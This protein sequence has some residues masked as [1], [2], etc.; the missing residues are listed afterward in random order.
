M[1]YFILKLIPFLLLL[2]VFSI[3]CDDKSTD[4]NNNTNNINNTQSLP[5]REDC[6]HFFVYEGQGASSVKLVGSFNEW[7]I[8][9]GYPF[10][11]DGFNWTLA[12]TSN[13]NHED[14]GIIL[15]PP[16]NYPYKFVI[17]DETWIM[18]NKNPYTI[19]DKTQ[20]FEN[21]LLSLP[22]CNA[23]QIYEET[24]EIDFANG[25]LTFTFQLALS[26]RNS[27]ISD[28]QVTVYE[29]EE[30]IESSLDYDNDTGLGSVSLQGLSLGKFNINIIAT[31]T[32]GDK[33]DK[34]FA[35]WFEE[36]NKNWEDLILYSIFV[37]RF[38]NGDPT[39]DKPVEDLEEIVNWQG[40][41]WKG[42]TAKIK[43]GYFDDLGIN[44][45]WIS[46][47]MDN[48]DYALPGDCNQVF[49]GYHAY[50]PQASRKTENHFG[51][52]ADLKELVQEAH[53]RGIRV[54]ID[55]AANHIFIEH[56]LHQEYF[57]NPYWF[58][59]PGSSN[60]EDFWRNKCGE[61][62]WNEYALTC[63]FTEYLPD[64]N[65]RN[66]ELVEQMIIDAIWW[67]NT[68]D[69]DGFRVDATKHIRSNYL[70]L[71]RRELDREFT[72]STAPFYMVGENFLY[73]YNELDEKISP[74]ELNGQFDFPLYGTIRST[75]IP[76]EVDLTQLNSFVYGNFI[77][78]QSIT[79]LDWDQ[80]GY[81]IS[82]TLMGNFLGNHDVERFS[83]VAAGDA[84]G[85]GCQIFNEPAPLQ[86]NNEDIYK[87][88]AVA[89]GFLLTVR[90]L[91]VI[92][93]GDEI[94]L[95]GVKDPDNRRF[96]IFDE[97][98]LMPA[99]IEL[100]QLVSSLNHLRLEYPSLRLGKYDAFHGEPSCLVYLKSYENENILVALSGQDGCN[101]SVNMKSEYNFADG[102]VLEELLYGEEELTISNQ[103][104]Q[105]S[106]PANAIGIYFIHP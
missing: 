92:Y 106:I 32:A 50:W 54:L 11:Q 91:P 41:D 78:S 82:G 36:K 89:F 27:G 57:G 59:Y 31:N 94:G 28:V 56:E 96:M 95:A 30:I 86:T 29:G 61:L 102:Q 34:T 80:E 39:N 18:D 72:T 62:G 97:S 16:G 44:S 48:P 7:K 71:L 45:L 64:Y 67:V 75:F 15:L 12:V 40:G 87:R 52:A 85:D 103:T 33:V 21:S 70:K 90:G 22:A 4:N 13:P 101:A 73:D 60:Y 99:Q 53:K 37:D 46:T 42:I 19:Y 49:S 25:E 35:V 77:D 47:P 23:P 69:L 68:F 2:S 43:S 76:A 88:M 8:E 83:S 84:N 79:N 74:A 51:T 55:W 5:L 105:I 66:Q 17:D 65:H 14:S 104:V 100:K 3:S 93:Y 24:T 38:H 10:S 81:N 63:W 26:H 98:S 9:N 6:T 20:Q 58:N 1:K